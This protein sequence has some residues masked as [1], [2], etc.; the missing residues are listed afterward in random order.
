MSRSGTVKV[1]DCDRTFI[2]FGKSNS[3][4]SALGNLLLGSHATTHFSTHPLHE[5]SG[6]TK[7][8]QSGESE[9]DAKIVYGEGYT[10]HNRVKIQVIDQPGCNDNDHAIFSNQ[11]LEMSK[12]KRKTTFLIV[13][14]LTSRYFSQDEFLSVMRMAEILSENKHCFFSNAI[15]VSTHADILDKHLRKD[16]LKE[17]VHQKLQQEDFGYIQALLDLVEHRYMFVNAV[18]NGEVNRGDTL[19]ELFQ[20]T[21]PTLNVCIDGNTGF[22]GRDL[23]LLLRS[24]PTIN[25]IRKDTPIYDVEYHFNPELNPITRDDIKLMKGKIAHALDKLDKI[26]NGISAIVILINLEENFREEIYNHILNL[27]DAYSLGDKSKQHFWDFASI[28]FK[29][30]S[31]SKDYVRREIDVNLRLKNLDKLVQSRYCWITDRTSPEECNKKL[32]NLVNEVASYNHWKTFTDS[33]VVTELRDN[34][35]EWFTLKHLRIPPVK[36]P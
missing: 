20:L 16:K 26:S 14:N 21:K 17:I 18:N 33:T 13:I 8:M 7:K 15:I 2:L 10:G 30:G 9:I 6:H 36:N 5:P 34:K 32:G 27:P 28:I 25:N 11:C 19:E 23:K 29:V 35:Q 31:D 24:E 22:I 3:G 4:K 12:S 1:R